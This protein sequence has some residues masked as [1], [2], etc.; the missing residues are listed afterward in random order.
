MKQMKVTRPRS[1]QSE[2]TIVNSVAPQ[3]TFATAVLFILIQRGV[4]V[5]RQRS[6]SVKKQN[7]QAFEH[8]S[9]DEDVD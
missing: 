2:L 6:S 5:G 3:L 8:C 7:F 4:V 9:K 1:R